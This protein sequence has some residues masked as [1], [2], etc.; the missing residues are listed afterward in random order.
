[1]RKDPVLILALGA[2]I[3]VTLMALWMIAYAQ[4]T[5][6]TRGI[7]GGVLA[8]ILLPG[9]VTLAGNR[10]ARFAA[11]ALVLVIVIGAAIV[12]LVAGGVATPAVVLL[13]AAMLEFAALVSLSRH[14]PQREPSEPAQP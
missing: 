11:V 14:P 5:L 7:L 3:V 2:H 1:V 10:R 12:E 6:S 13:G 8:A 4:L 9:L